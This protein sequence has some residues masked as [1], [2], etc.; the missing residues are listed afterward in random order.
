MAR[1]PNPN[2]RTI[3]F[4]KLDGSGGRT[5]LRL[6]RVA[7]KD[8]PV[9]R[10]HVDAM[11]ARARNA[12]PLPAAT[13]GWLK[14]IGDQLHTR[15]AKAGLVE[16]RSSAGAELGTF[17]ADYLERR[18][19][20]KPNTRKNYSQSRDALVAYFGPARKLRTLTKGEM[21]DWRRWLADPKGGNYS[22][23]TVAVFVKKGRL[24]FADAVD[25]KVIPENPLTG[26]RAGKM[27]N[28]ARRIYVPAA[29]VLRA[30]DKCPDA[31]WRLIFALA[32]FAGIRTPSELLPL[33]WSHVDW[34]RERILIT[35][36][37]TE[38]IEG[39]ATREIPIFAPLRPYLREAYE[40]AEEGKRYVIT[41]HRNVVNLRTRAV[42]IVKRAGLARWPKLFQN[43]RAS[44]ETDLVAHF[45]IHVVCAW[46]GNTEAVALAHY[47]SVTD[48]DFE[49]ATLIGEGAAESA[50]LASAIY[51]PIPEPSGEKL[52]FLPEN[53][54]FM[55]PV[56]AESRWEKAEKLH[57]DSKVVR[58]ALHALKE[59]APYIREAEILNLR[60]ELNAAK[61]RARGQA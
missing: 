59:A 29:S 19:D 9:V 56:G 60:R 26:V 57:L 38:H 31:E 12:M 35:S 53:M 1:K 18:T 22:P 54:V 61:R 32:R 51:R 6:G 7:A 14:E 30:I 3:Q 58:K 39:K 28:D 5:T 48:D 23:A 40:Q 4:P 43:L 24:M 52:L 49:R 42:K 44:C 15:I 11:L 25:H 16:P 21:K 20:V 10:A 37:K 34:G 46:I 36:P 27:T 33:E 41:K 8:W 2:L 55:P 13:V 50:D 47:L 45:P 17:L